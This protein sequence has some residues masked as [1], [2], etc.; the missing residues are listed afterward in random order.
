MIVNPSSLQRLLLAILL[1]LAVAIPGVA[2][3]KNVR[4]ERY[5][6]YAMLDP[7]GTLDVEERVVFVLT[8]RPF[9]RIYRQSRCG[10][11]TA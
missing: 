5:D 1:G 6:V 7:T 3:G 11:P 4:V 8:G 2:A 9:T 10:S